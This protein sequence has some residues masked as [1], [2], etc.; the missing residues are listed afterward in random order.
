MLIRDQAGRT[1]RLFLYSGIFWFVVAAFVGMLV[2][3]SA[4]GVADALVGPDM[5]EMIRVDRLQPVFLNTLV[6]GWAAM[7]G[8]GL[9]LLIV[10][11]SYGL[12]LNNEP[13]GQF[14]VW[15]WNLVLAGGAG[16]AALGFREGPA[17]AEFVW[18][19]K[20]G[21]FI[22][23][24][25]LLFN[26][27]LTV[28][29]VRQP[30][31][32]S[33]WFLLG[34]LTWSA[35]VWFVGNALWWTNGLGR[36]PLSALLYSFYTEG[37]IW[38]WA[39]P[40][41]S[42]VALF[43][44]P[45]LSNQP[46]YS[47]KLAH[48][49]FWLLAFHAGAGTYRLWGANIPATLHAA[50]AGMGALTLVAAVAIVANVYKTIGK[51]RETVGASA[52]GRALLIG[53]AFLFV[54][55]LQ[56]T[57]QPLT[58]LLPS[59]QSTQLAVGQHFT[60]LL[61]GVTLLLIAGAYTLLPMLR[62]PKD[63]PAPESDVVLYN[64]GVARWNVTLSTLGAGLFIVGVWIGGALQLD[65][66]AAHGAFANMAAPLQPALLMQAGGMALLLGA[67]LL[68]AYNVVR[69]ASARQPIHLPVV[70]TNPGPETPP[71]N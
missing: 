36:D 62:Q 31:Y 61:G 13:L 27:A 26:V 37:L 38:L 28:K 65:A 53:T 47:R 51:S 68:L 21:L 69:A 19:F 70:L 46:L 56:A 60:A 6:L 4:L 30:L 54:A 66:R 16:M 71:S 9:G 52:P 33:V 32:A 24:A 44:A 49:G 8:T 58:I 50:G 11:R 59:V 55:A 22:A 40:L 25:L 14:S 39:V 67:Q 63:R 48:Y 29:N 23:L 57:L 10:Q 42:G 64:E 18:P 35:V 3:L 12:A 5:L 41:A 20:L 1:A 43:V 7:A 15:L 17:Y 2:A 45:V 34:G